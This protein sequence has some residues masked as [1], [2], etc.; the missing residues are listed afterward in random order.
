M[1]ERRVQMVVDGRKGATTGLPQGSAVSP[2]LFA[3]YIAEVHEFV[4]SRVPG[5]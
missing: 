4:E 2:I 5:V 1:T 3:I